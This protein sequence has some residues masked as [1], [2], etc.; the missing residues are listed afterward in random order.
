[1]A[2][3]DEALRAREL[4]ILLKKKRTRREDKISQQEVVLRNKPLI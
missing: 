1:M 4:T 3:A 2:K